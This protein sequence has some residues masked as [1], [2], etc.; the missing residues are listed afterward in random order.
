MT[1]KDFIKTADTFKGLKP[2]DPVLL[3][4]W[5]KYVEDMCAVFTKDNPR[6]DENRFKAACGW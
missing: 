4:N 2:S 5:R 3:L 6:F 1:K